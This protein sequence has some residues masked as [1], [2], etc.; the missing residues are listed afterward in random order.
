MYPD[1]IETDTKDPTVSKII[2]MFLRNTKRICSGLP[3]STLQ[4]ANL[5][6]RRK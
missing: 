6:A 5:K 3:N 2:E 1:N 4:I